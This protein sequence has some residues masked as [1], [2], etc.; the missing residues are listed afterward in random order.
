MFEDTYVQGGSDH[1]SGRASLHSVKPVTKISKPGY[2]IVLLVK[3]L[4]SS[5]EAGRL[6]IQ[7]LAHLPDL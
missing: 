4:R 6:G 5:L 7:A 1:T 2:N 3:A